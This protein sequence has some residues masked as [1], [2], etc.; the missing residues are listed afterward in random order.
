MAGHKHAFREGDVACSERIKRRD[1]YDRQDCQNSRQPST[2]AVCRIVD[3]DESFDNTTDGQ[4]FYCNSAL[5]RNCRKPSGTVR[6]TA[7]PSNG[8]AFGDV[9]ELAA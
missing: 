7:L 1:E 4:G 3:S 8:S 2:W 6:Q 5:P 9:V